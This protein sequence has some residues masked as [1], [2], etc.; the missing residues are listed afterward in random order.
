MKS[1]RAALGNLISNYFTLIFL[2]IILGLFVIMSPLIKISVGELS[3]NSNEDISLEGYALLFQKLNEEMT[4][5]LLNSDLIDINSITVVPN[6]LQNTNEIYFFFNNQDELLISINSDECL[7]SEIDVGCSKTTKDGC[8][9][10][11]IQSYTCPDLNGKNITPLIATSLDILK[12]KVDSK[13]QKE[14]LKTEGYSWEV[15]SYE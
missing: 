5:V 4:D 9:E 7:F 1:K 14:Y 8:V 3:L 2:A 13:S 11:I 12:D 15:Y 10:H 6:K